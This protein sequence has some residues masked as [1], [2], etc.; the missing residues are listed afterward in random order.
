MGFLTASL[1]AA[2]VASSVSQGIGARKA[3]NAATAEGARLAAD[4]K[5][6]GE[7]D[8][9]RYRRDLD[10]IVSQ[11]RVLS[12]AQGVDINQGTAAAVQADT[13]RIG[14]MDIA[15]IRENARREA[16]GLRA[17]S[18][19]NAKSLRAGANAAFAN[20]GMTLLTNGVDAW[21][22]YSAG[23]SAMNS[24]RMAGGPARLPA[25]S[26]VFASRPSFSPV[27]P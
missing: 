1:V 6:R 18:E 20:A 10:Q 21:S 16:Y 14:D 23:K 7:E 3:A 9:A 17:N 12:A 8:V 2:S 13:R 26:N 25:R 27:R 11:Q 19:V 4:A 24:A 22:N 15:T 5:V